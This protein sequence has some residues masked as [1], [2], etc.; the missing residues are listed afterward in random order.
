MSSDEQKVWGDIVVTD[1]GSFAILT[2]SR[3]SKRNA[4]KSQ[5]PAK[6]DAGAQLSER[7]LPGGHPHGNG[8]LFFCAGIDLKERADDVARGDFSASAEWIDVNVAI[9]EHPS[10]FIARRQ[11][12]CIGRRSY[13]NQRL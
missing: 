2:I 1:R 6:P 4:V 8:V 9:R 5:L 11:R 7:S 10:I 3:E 12:S 13:A